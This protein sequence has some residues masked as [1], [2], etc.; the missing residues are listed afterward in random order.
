[1]VS[2]SQMKNLSL[3]SVFL[4]EIKLETFELLVSASGK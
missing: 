1:M 3:Y 4:Y 2:V